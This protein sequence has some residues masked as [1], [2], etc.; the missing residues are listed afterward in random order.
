MSTFIILWVAPC[1]VP[2]L[3]DYRREETDILILKTKRR[4]LDFISLT[5]H[6]LHRM[7]SPDWLV[8]FS[9]FQSEGFQPAVVCSSASL[10]CACDWKVDLSLVLLFLWLALL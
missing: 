4:G 10:T 9:H 6:I 5:N 2:L 8:F 1:E 3:G 7:T